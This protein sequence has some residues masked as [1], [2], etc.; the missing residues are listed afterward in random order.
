MERACVTILG[1]EWIIEYRDIEQ[2]KYLG[3][4]GADGYCDPSLHL[5]VVCNNYEDVE[6]G[7]FKSYQKQVLRHEI[8]HAFMYESGLGSDWEH[9]Q[10][11]QEE[12]TVDWIARQFPKLLKAFK[13]AK[14][15]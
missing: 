10:Y 14:A 12:T 2:D 15:L 11:G 7:D 5:I 4:N 3:K 8:V 1:N 9:K 6:L 13:E